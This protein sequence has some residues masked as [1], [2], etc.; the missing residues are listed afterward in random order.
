[1]RAGNCILKAIHAP[2]LS[3]R[4]ILTDKPG[5]YTATLYRT[6]NLRVPGGFSFSKDYKKKKNK[7]KQNELLKKH[8]AST[9]LVL[10]GFWSGQWYS[11][12]V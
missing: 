8:T 9:S 11:M 7:V 5:V 4:N 1:M 10:G 12:L 6:E 2:V 3:D